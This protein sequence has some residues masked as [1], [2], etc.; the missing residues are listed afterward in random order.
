MA[1]DQGVYAILERGPAQAIDRTFR[2]LQQYVLDLLDELEGDGALLKTDVFNINRADRLID[3]LR[4]ELGSLGFNDVIDAELESLKEMITAIKKE[5]GELGIG[6]EFS[7]TSNELIRS[8][9]RRSSTATFNVAQQ[10]AQE[11]DDLVHDSIMGQVDFKQITRALQTKLG[12]RQDQMHSLVS[13]TLHN[14]TRQVRATHAAEAGVEWFLY[15]G[16]QDTANRD[17]CA[18]C[19]GRRFTR[20]MLESMA[21]EFGRSPK[22]IPVSIWL[23]GYR[24]RHELV[25]LVDA[26]DIRLYEIGAR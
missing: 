25:P 4:A 23:G 12:F 6:S 11:L 15:D 10:V 5:G 19:V 21:G 17:F 7:D 9:F 14:F 2:K 16:P 26:K 18:H 22:L 1:I 24:C 8:L 20:D 13:S 3:K